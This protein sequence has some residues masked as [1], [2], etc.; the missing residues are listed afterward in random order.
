MARAQDTGRGI[1]PAASAEAKRRRSTGRP[2][3]RPRVARGTLRRADILDAALD[4]VAREPARPLTMERVAAALGTRPMS[5][6]THVRNRDDLI[7]GA[8]DQVLARWRPGELAGPWEDAVRA[9]CQALRTVALP[10]APLLRELARPGH[11]H[12]G[13]LECAA[14]LSAVLRRAGLTGAAHARAVRWIP[15]TILGA[16]LLEAERP[17]H[18]K[19]VGDESAAI[20]GALGRVGVASRQEL[21]ALLPYF[22]DLAEDDLF[23]YTVER[24]LDGLRA[25]LTE[26]EPATNERTDS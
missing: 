17:S 22:D 19:H 18:L 6:Y 14:R 25:V 24:L 1:L 9:W 8:F 12:P 21:A 10:Y 13:L 26:G 3:P 23:A 16:I 5:L 7:E 11:F 2:A 4:L 15:Q 20:A